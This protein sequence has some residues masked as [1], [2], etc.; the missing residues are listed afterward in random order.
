M[1][2]L[3]KKP[4]MP[5]IPPPPPPPAPPPRLETMGE[6]AKRLRKKAKGRAFTVLTG[7]LTPFDIGKKS[8]LG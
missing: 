3:F 4:K 1:G 2:S 8:L 5:K 6:P 7:D